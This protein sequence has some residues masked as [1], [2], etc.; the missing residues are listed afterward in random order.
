MPTGSISVQPYLGLILP[1]FSVAHTFSLYRYVHVHI[2]SKPS[3][4]TIQL[5]HNSLNPKFIKQN[6]AIIFKT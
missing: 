1:A 3:L 2:T 5:L 6:S 4:A